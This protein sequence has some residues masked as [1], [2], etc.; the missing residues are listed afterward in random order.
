[1]EE[2]KRREE[3]CL[4][5]VDGGKRMIR[6]SRSFDKKQHW[7]MEEWRRGT[8]PLSLPEPWITSPPLQQTGHSCNLGAKRQSSV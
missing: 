8:L 5:W 3:N 6:T 2:K 4:S 7:G 1:M